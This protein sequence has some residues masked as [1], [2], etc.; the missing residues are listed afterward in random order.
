MNA[1]AFVVS[2]VALYAA[3]QVADH[4][5]Q[6]DSQACTKGEPGWRG[7]IACAS[8]VATYTA[9][10][11]VALYVAYW[12]TGLHPPI[13]NA[14]AG[15]TVSAITHYIADRRAPLR[16]IA[17]AVGS[18]KF[19]RV[20]ANGICGAYLLDQSWHIGFLFVAALIIA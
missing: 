16:R 11:V 18:G 7:R 17:D 3:H 19:Y 4:W 6:T 15:L 10:G 8:H 1:A 9:T 5:V 20:N 13:G 12:R 2:F 14:A